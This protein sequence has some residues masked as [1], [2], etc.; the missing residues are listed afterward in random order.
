MAPVNFWIAPVNFWKTIILPPPPLVNNTTRSYNHFTLP[1]IAQQQVTIY[2]PPPKISAGRGLVQK[3]VKIIFKSAKTTYSTNWI[4]QKME[5]SWKKARNYQFD[6][7][8][9]KYGKL[10]TLLLA[11]PANALL[12][13]MVFFFLLVVVTWFM[14]HI[15]PPCLHF[16]AKISKKSVFQSMRLCWR[17]AEDFS[18]CAVCVWNG[19]L[20]RRWNKFLDSWSISSKRKFL[21]LVW[22]RNLAAMLTDLAFTTVSSYHGTFL[23]KS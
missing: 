3:S 22:Q 6:L 19:N 13:A 23:E 7:K 18:L 11:F 1:E 17:A 9:A 20:S 4:G 8:K 15:F 21:W 5:W 2:F 10:A 12:I 14:Y 16:T